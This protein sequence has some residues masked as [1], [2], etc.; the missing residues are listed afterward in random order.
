MTYTTDPILAV[1]AALTDEQ[2]D[3]IVGR[4]TRINPHWRGAQPADIL[5]ALTE[6][7][8]DLDRTE[9]FFEDTDDTDWP[10]GAAVAARALLWSGQ[11][12]TE[13]NM[14]DLLTEAGLMGEGR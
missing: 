5:D 7:D 10:E 4:F 9:P 14:R 2:Q 11:E 8:S 6:S 13:A 12:L 3:T 1:V